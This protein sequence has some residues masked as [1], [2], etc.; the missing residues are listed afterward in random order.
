MADDTPKGAISFDDIVRYLQTTEG[1]AN[2]A[3][4]QELI[5][6]NGRFV[7][8]PD[9]LSQEELCTLLEVN[10]KAVDSRTKCTCNAGIAEHRS[11]C[12]MYPYGPRRER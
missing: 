6:L 11:W 7:D 9:S 3:R 5:D 4:M 12:P 1:F 10:L 8:D 2:P